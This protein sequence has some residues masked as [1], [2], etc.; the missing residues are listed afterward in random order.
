MD[1]EDM[2]DTTF[3]FL[4]ERDERKFARPEQ[5]EARRP[6]RPTVQGPTVQ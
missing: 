3:L 6:G 2:A 4:P 1:I 5:P